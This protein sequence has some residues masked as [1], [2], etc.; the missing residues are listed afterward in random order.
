MTL[1][2]SNFSFLNPFCIFALSPYTPVD[3][4]GRLR[5]TPIFPHRSHGNME[6][7]RRRQKLLSCIPTG[8][9]VHQ[10]DAK[11]ENLTFRKWREPAQASVLSILF[12]ASHRGV[13]VDGLFAYFGRIWTDIIKAIMLHIAS[14]LPNKIMPN[15]RKGNEG[16]LTMYLNRDWHHP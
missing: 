4:H 6:S 8:W 15:Y 10:I 11:V 16:V 3:F 2:V 5:K 7:W 14:V 1:L 9:M 12:I 13:D